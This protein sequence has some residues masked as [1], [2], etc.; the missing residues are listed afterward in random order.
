M[1][2]PDKALNEIETREDLA[3]LTGL[4]EKIGNGSLSVENSSTET[5]VDAAGRWTKLGI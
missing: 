5:F 2:W 1:N 4:A 3:Y